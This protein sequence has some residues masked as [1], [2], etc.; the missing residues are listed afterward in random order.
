[1]HII[2]SNVASITDSENTLKM[3]RVIALL[4]IL[5]KYLLLRLK[6]ILQ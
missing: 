6:K 2:K 4:I 5:L 1:M 3:A